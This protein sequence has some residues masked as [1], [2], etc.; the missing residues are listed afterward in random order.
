MN[1]A[2]HV[3]QS[4]QT[5]SVSDE[6]ENHQE[7]KLQKW[8]NLSAVNFGAWSHHSSC[9]NLLGENAPSKKQVSPDKLYRAALLRS[10]FA[11]TILKAQE[12]TLEKVCY[13][14]E[15]AFVDFDV[16]HPNCNLWI[17]RLWCFSYIHCN[18]SC[19]FCLFC[20]KFCLKIGWLNWSWSQGDKW[21]PEKL[22]M[23]RKELERRQKEGLFSFWTLKCFLR[24]TCVTALV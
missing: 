5:D 4:S 14:C 1:A 12:K 3:E 11:D 19:M 6:P 16:L 9:C 8:R 24:L 18:L 21:D 22:R 7:G 23:E 10:R 13:G 17:K 2:G 20:S 15:I